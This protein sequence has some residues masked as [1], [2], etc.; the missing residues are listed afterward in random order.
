MDRVRQFRKR[1]KECRNAAAKAAPEIRAHYEEIAEVW[2]KLAEERLMYFV[3]PT[4]A[5]S[6]SELAEADEA[7]C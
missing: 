3:A 6:Q 7:S 2:E 1:A 4:E 5:E